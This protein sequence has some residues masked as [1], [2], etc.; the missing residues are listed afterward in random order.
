MYIKIA[1]ELVRLYPPKI[2]YNLNADYQVK[3]Q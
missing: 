3:P 1:A 2:I